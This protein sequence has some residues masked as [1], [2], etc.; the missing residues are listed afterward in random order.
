MA[1]PDPDYRPPILRDR[2]GEQIVFSPSTH[3]IFGKLPF[4]NIK[5]LPFENSV[6]LNAVLFNSWD[7]N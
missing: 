5:P 2:E 6:V 7:E 4:S 3:E 1:A